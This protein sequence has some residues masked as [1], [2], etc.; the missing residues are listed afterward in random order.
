MTYELRNLAMLPNDISLDWDRR[1]GNVGVKTRVFAK[2][3]RL[4]SEDFHLGAHNAYFPRLGAM[5]VAG[6]EG[7]I[8]EDEARQGLKIVETNKTPGNDD[9]P[10][11]V[12]LGLSHIFQ[13]SLI[14]VY[15]NWMKRLTIPQ[16]LP[17]DILNLLCKNKPG[18][19]ISNFRPLTIINNDLKTLVNILVDCHA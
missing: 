2:S 9:L 12:Y 19:R 10:H 4:H 13:P 5:K 14:T 16:C 7:R 6:Y 18:D 15:N 1:M 3:S 8:I 17:R 11:E